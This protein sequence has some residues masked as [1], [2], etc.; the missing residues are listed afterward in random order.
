MRRLQ[1][2]VDDGGKGFGGLIIEKL[3][4]LT[5]RRWQ[6]D[7]IKRR[8]AYQFPSGCGANRAE[9]PFFLFGENERIDRRLGP[10]RVLYVR[11]RM[12]DGDPISPGLPRLGPV[13]FF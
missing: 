13:H 3:F 2:P 11:L 4:D 12:F 1:Q 7:Q 8:P 6:A 5:G 9:S 10:V